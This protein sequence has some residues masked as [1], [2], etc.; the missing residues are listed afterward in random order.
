MGFTLLFDYV[1]G[2]TYGAMSWGDT[3]FVFLDCGEDKPDTHPVYYG[4]NDFS[5]LRAQQL[6]FLKQEHQSTEFRKAKKRI[7]VHHIPLWGLGEPYNPCLDLW[8][9]E[10]SSQPYDIAINGHTHSKAFHP[11]GSIDNPFPVAIGGGYTLES[12]T[13]MHLSKRGSKLRLD[14]YN[15]KAEVVF[16][17]S[18]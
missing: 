4:L 3:R 18:N 10:L 15:T 12:A 5:G 17:F 7:L 11:K 9:A 16:S 14:C 2:K 13:V 1:G 6:E 8:S